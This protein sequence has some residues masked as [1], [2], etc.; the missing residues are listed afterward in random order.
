MTHEAFA[1]A[2]ESAAGALWGPP[3]MALLV[4]TG[5]YLTIG[6]RGISFTRLPEALCLMASPAARGKAAGAG[7]ISPF[8]ALM[9]AVSAT[10]GVGNIAGV[11]TAI[12]LGGPGALAWMWAVGCVGMATKYTEAFLS[13]RYRQRNGDQFLGGPMYYIALGMGPGWAWLGAVYAAFGA[14]AALGAGAGVQANTIADALQSSFS[15]NTTRSTVALTVLTFA[16]VVGGLKRIAAISEILA[17]FM[18][19]L[20]MICGTAV[21]ALNAAHLPGAFTLIFDGAFHGAA[22]AGGFAGAAVAATARYGVA[23]GLF[24]NEAGLGSAAIMHAASRS[25]DPVQIGALGMLGVFIDTLVVNSVTGLTIVVTGAWTLDITGAPLT[26]AA[27]ASV[28]P[29][30]DIVVTLSLLLFAFTTIIG[31]C[32]YGER[33]AGYLLGLHGARGYRILWCA[34]ILAGGMAHLDVAWLV[35]DITNALMAVPN[36]IALLALSPGVFAATR[37]RLAGGRPL[38]L[39]A[40]LPNSP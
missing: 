39:P 14:I 4:G 10:V 8:A 18:I 37:A 33:C 21:I 15:V 13:I 36:L 40:D 25:D 20:F 19:A 11:A 5:L 24:S 3:L 29:A 12:H 28:L 9:S 22:A 31:W 27:F 2:L 6:L 16:V 17:P 35:T 23:R 7:E 34:A 26:A 38:A 32:V 1:K 30:G